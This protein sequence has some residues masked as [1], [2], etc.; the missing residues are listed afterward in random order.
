MRLFIGV[1]PPEVV[2][3][4]VG[5]LSDRLQRSLGA[6]AAEALRWTT[7][8]QW[9]VTL[10][11]LG[12]VGDPA[13]VVAA[14]DTADVRST[15]AWLGPAARWLGG[16]VLYLPVAGLD[17]LAAGVAAATAA[18][19]RPPEDR[20]FVGHVTLARLRRP[21]PRHRRAGRDR[22][23]RDRSVRR[24]LDLG[25]AAIEARWV[26][27]EVVLVRSHLGRAGSRYE[28]VH[29]RRLPV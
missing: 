29:R 4:Q 8:D 25:G 10:R 9:H 11:F 16:Q 13:P 2:L 6:E 21:S 22:S 3:D 17:E 26:V 27:G 19:G 14:L 24:R 18:L 20:R 28:D 5:D 23:G 1:R 12:E 7:R 15:E